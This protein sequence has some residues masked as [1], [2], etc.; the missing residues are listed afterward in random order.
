MEKKFL[1]FY[2][3]PA[4]EVVELEVEGFLCASGDIEGVDN[5]D[6]LNGGNDNPGF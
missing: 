6:D 2:E 5:Q 1:K 4:T 3:A